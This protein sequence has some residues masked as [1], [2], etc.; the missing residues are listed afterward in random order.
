MKKEYKIFILLFIL[1]LIILTLLY[2][3]YYSKINLQLVISRYN[4]DLEW[5]K[6]Y[7]FNKYPSICYNKGNNNDFYR[8]KNMKVVNLKNVGRCDH[9]Y[10]YHIVNNYD[11]LYDYIMFLPGSCNLPYKKDKAV[12]WIKELERRRSYVFI[13]SKY[14][15]GIRRD[16]YNFQLDHYTSSDNKNKKLNP[17]SK[18]YL[19]ENR[20]FGN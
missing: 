2:V 20:P 15:N 12:K 5:L 11:N 1:M 10:I 16:L 9:T 18:L 17:E 13:G 14:D 6:E 19:S 3:I 8:P 7:P 4:E